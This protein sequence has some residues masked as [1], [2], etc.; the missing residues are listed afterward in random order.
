MKKEVTYVLQTGICKK[1][2]I[3]R[4]SSGRTEDTNILMAVF[5]EQQMCNQLDNE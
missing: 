5:L 2:F 3:Y 1:V 4:R